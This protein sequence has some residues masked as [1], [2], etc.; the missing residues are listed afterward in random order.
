MTLGAGAPAAAST[1][2]AMP[3]APGRGAAGG[4]A[5]DLAHAPRH[6]VGRAQRAQVEVAEAVERDDVMTPADRQLGEHPRAHRDE[7]DRLGRRPEA[8]QSVPS[9]SATNSTA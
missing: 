6:G 8:A 7:E 5:H 3:P 4:G 2:S 1:I 9:S